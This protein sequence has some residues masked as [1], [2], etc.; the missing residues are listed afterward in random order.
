MR[1]VEDSVSG[2]IVFERIKRCAE[3][4]VGAKVVRP[5]ADGLLQRAT[6]LSEPPE[7]EV[8]QAK[9]VIDLERLRIQFCCTLKR[10][11]GLLIFTVPSVQHA[12]RGELIR[13]VGIKQM[14]ADI[15]ASAG[16]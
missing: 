3:E 4:R 12:E 16:F 7:P 2:R 10:L 5:Q 11:D 9:I 8:S 6:R 14:I 15:P 1:K 13:I